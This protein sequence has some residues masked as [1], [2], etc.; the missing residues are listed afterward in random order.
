MT[1]AQGATT[2]TQMLCMSANSVYA[3]TYCLSMSCSAI[4]L[5]WLAGVRMIIEGSVLTYYGPGGFKYEHCNTVCVCNIMHSALQLV[6]S[7]HLLATGVQ[8]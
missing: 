4:H 3:I 6:W 2:C 5:V 7:H 8:H 1:T